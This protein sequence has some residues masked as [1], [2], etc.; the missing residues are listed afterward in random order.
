MGPSWESV[1][2][3]AQ[4]PSMG[5][6]ARC[7][8]SKQAA[9][10]GINHEGVKGRLLTSIAWVSQTCVYFCGKGIKGHT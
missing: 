7:R 10:R 1:E 8:G 6:W 4:R 2:S 5:A 9:K 3:R